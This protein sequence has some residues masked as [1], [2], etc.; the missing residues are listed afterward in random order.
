MLA[1]LTYFIW[2]GNIK[3]CV[4][5]EVR[6]KVRLRWLLRWR[7]GALFPVYRDTTWITG[8]SASAI[9]TRQ[10]V[11]SPCFSSAATS[12]EDGSVL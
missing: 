2:D 5:H 1:S 9:Q 4:I 12:S 7:V 8:V 3:E 6:E 11:W 10:T